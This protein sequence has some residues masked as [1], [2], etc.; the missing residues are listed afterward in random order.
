MEENK[1]KVETIMDTANTKET[2]NKNKKEKNR[3]RMILVI[4][5]LIVFA[6]I[7]YVQLRGSY[8]EYLELGEKYVDIFHTNMIYKYIIMAINF[9]VLYGIIY[10]TNRG[11]KKGLKPFFEKENK[12]MPKLLNKSLALVISAIVSIIVATTLMQKVMLVMNSTAFGIQDMIFNLDISYYIFQKPVI[13]AIALYFT[14]LMVGLSIYMALYYVIIFN[15]FFDG[16]DGKMLKQSLFMKKLTRNILL[17][18]VGIAIMTLLN[19]QNMVFGK[20]L[21]INDEIDIVGAGLTETT[22]KLWGY[23]IFAFVI[24]IFSYRALKY[25]KEGNNNKVLKNLALIPSYLVILFI[26]MMIFDLLFVSSNELDKEKEYLAENINSTK[27]AYR[28]NIEEKS[29]KNSGTITSEEVEK[30]NNTI[31]NIP[32]ISQNAVLKTLEDSQTETRIFFLSKC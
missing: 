12:P 26:V 29:I 32:I 18:I 14:V 2:K 5:F 11:I 22:V 15:R 8:L 31:S 20:L 23:I 19:T 10:F 30:N 9:V 4:L 1:P 28:I 7:S 13:E 16:I 25:F 21:T 17:V 27:N 3:T 24:V 6:G